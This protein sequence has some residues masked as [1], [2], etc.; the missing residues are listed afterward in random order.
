MHLTMLVIFVILLTWFIR[1]SVG[2]EQTLSWDNYRHTELQNI[3]TINSAI[4]YHPITVRMATIPRFLLLRSSPAAAPV[5]HGG[6]AVP[7]ITALESKCIRLLITTRS[8]R[9]QEGCSNTRYLTSVSHSPKEDVVRLRASRVCYLI[10]F[11][12]QRFSGCTWR[13]RCHAFWPVWREWGRKS[14]QRL[15]SISDVLLSA[16]RRVCAHVGSCVWLI[17]WALLLGISTDWEIKCRRQSVRFERR[18]SSS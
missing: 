4:W 5:E 9:N 8:V 15:E 7:T 14:P 6:S 18:T 1:G 3:S 17:L 10:L 2:P 16:G 11:Y 13:R 12:W